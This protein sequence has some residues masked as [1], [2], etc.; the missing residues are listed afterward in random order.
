MPLIPFFAVL[1]VA[2]MARA[3][4]RVAA[5]NAGQ[6]ASRSSLVPLKDGLQ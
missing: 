3:P 4:A 2:L 5:F 6:R 1:L